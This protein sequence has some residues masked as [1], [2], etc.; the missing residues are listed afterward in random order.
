MK[1]FMGMAASFCLTI[2]TAPNGWYGASL[3]C[4]LFCLDLIINENKND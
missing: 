1:V 2:A 3:I 4:T